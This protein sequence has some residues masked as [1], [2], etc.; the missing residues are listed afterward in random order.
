MGVPLDEKFYIDENENIICP[1]CL[2]RLNRAQKKGIPNVYLLLLDLTQHE[3]IEIPYE[4]KTRAFIRNKIASTIQYMRRKWGRAYA[5]RD[6]SE[7]GIFFLIR[8]I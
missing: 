7:R 3:H 8:V 1:K 2:K 4:E 6:N 5:L